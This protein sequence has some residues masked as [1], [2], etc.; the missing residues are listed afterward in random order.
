MS[1]VSNML[2]NDL[3]AIDLND[4]NIQ[5]EEDQVK[6]PVKKVHE[7]V[8]KVGADLIKVGADSDSMNS[9]GGISAASLSL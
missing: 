2:L 9:D 3:P 1:V 6:T 8:I 5:I 7:N 4:V